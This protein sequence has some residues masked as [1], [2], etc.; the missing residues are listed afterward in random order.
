MLKNN[1]AVSTLA[2]I[3]IILFSIIFGALI[4]YLWVMGSFYLTPQNTTT[5]AITNVDFPLYHA[6]YFNLTVMNPS[7]SVYGTNITQIYYTVQDNTT[8]HN[9]ATT[10][11]SLPIPM[12]VGTEKSI[13]C[14]DTWGAYA[15]KNIT[16]NIIANNASGT[17]YT[18][19]T[20]FVALS[21]DTTFNA[22]QSINYFNVTATNNANSAINLTLSEVYFE[23]TKVQNMTLE[24]PRNLTKGA[25]VS[26]GCNVNW[27]GKLKPYVYVKTLEGYIGDIRKN[28]ASL[29]NLQVANVSFNYENPNEV[30]I[31]LANLPDSNVSYIDITN[32]AVK[33]DNNTQLTI[34]GTTTN[35]SFYPQPYKLNKGENITFN[36]CAWNWKNYRDRAFRV[37]VQT[38]QGINASTSSLTSPPSP[39][40]K[41]E[42]ITFNMNNTNYFTFTLR[43]RLSSLEA[44]TISKIEFI[45]GTSTVTMATTTPEL[46]C[47][48]TV[49]ASQT[50]NCTFDWSSFKGQNITLIIYTTQRINLTIPYTLPILTVSATFNG[51]L[52]IQYF[53]LTIQNKAYMPLNI[54]GINVNGTD[55]N[56]ALTYPTLPVKIEY[57]N[58]QQILCPYNWQPLSGKEITIIVVTSAGFNVTITVTVP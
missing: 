23:F 37:L 21:V 14:N 46:P 28:V 54:T 31:S 40:F 32:I 30:S 53:S 18:F 22:T 48:I 5:L 26:F 10:F 8:I 27:R 47:N 43:N 20:K 58:T 11:P 3:L 17:A 44:A 4:S 7:N 19:Q 25:S 57:L 36:N 41:L 33:L 50:I 51:N 49:G 16:V 12:N 39:S 55:I 56:T 45:H 52:S 6:N 2:L 9:V 24:F 42:Q 13:I 29:S 35:P 1:K 15:G 38:R 34:N